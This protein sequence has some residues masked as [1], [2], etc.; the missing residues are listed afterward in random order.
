MAEISPEKVTEI[1]DGFGEAMSRLMVDQ[2]QKHLS[3]LDL[4]LPQVQVLRILHREGTVPTGKLAQCLRISAPATTQLTDRLLRKGLIERRASE[5]DR[6]AVL[7]ALSAEGQGLIDKFRE[8]RNAIFGAALSQLSEAEQAQVVSSLQK[9]IRV[10][11]E[12]EAKN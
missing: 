9:V 3:E 1:L 2:L 8:R 4:T 10:L 12:F 7:V 11:T 5:D 6:R